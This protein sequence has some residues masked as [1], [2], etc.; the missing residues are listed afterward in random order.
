MLSTSGFVD[1]VVFSHIDPMAARCYYSIAATM[2]QNLL[3]GIGGAKA[4]SCPMSMGWVG[5]GCV[6]VENFC[7]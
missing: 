2:S 5:L 3:R 4:Q 6:W 1:N 7:F